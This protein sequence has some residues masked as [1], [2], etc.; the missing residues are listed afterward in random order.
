MNRRPTIVWFRH[1]LRTADQPALAA[2][3]Q[4]GGPVVPVF[5]G[6][7]EEDGQW[8]PGGAS[9]WWLRRSLI[10]LA[11]SLER[12]GSRSSFGAGRL[13]QPSAR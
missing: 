2:A 10:E 3:L 8:P 13:W 4:R 5:I 11:G 1:D 9:R 12:L 7:P 6:S